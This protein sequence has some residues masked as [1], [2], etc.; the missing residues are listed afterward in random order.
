M[1]DEPKHWTR[2]QLDAARDLLLIWGR[3]S[4]GDI[5]VIQA[6][7]RTSESFAGTVE[8]TA[9]FD[10]WDRLVRLGWAERRT[11]AAGLPDI[12]PRPA[13]FAPT[14]QGRELLPDFMRHYDMCEGRSFVLPSPPP[15]PALF[16]KVLDEAALYYLG[17][18]DYRRF[19]KDAAFR[20]RR[21]EAALVGLAIAA[22][23]ED[24]R[25]TAATLLELEA[26]EAGDELYRQRVGLIIRIDQNMA[27]DRGSLRPPYPVLRAIGARLDIGLGP[28][29][30]DWLR[31]G[32]LS[33]PALRAWNDQYGR[34]IE[35]FAS[36][37]AHW[38]DRAA[39]VAA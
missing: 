24:V 35:R 2:E 1:P 14:P 34:E 20:L 9:H 33:V 6:A 36:Y 26:A 32:T 39:K 18:Q 5:S 19:T 12:T 4:P 17:G 30:D 38:S 21:M 13:F 29:L 31:A 22:Y 15:K 27:M 23:A 7:L 16:E 11:P 28:D 3:L 10:F 37:A 8:G 25:L